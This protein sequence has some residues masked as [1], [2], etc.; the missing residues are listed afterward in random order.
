MGQLQQLLLATWWEYRHHHGAQA[1]AE[2]RNEF[3]GEGGD[4]MIRRAEKKYGYMVSS[5]SETCL[6]TSVPG[7]LVSYL[8]S[9]YGAGVDLTDGLSN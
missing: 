3:E 5:M 6:R 9:D 8:N 2:R 1:G 4:D 7:P